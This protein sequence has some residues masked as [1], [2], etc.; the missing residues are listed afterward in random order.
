LVVDPA[1]LNLEA[2]LVMALLDSGA[3]A[4]AAHQYAHF[5]R[6]YE[7]DLGATPPS[8]ADL[9]LR[10]PGLWPTLRRTSAPK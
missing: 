6:A 4:A 2:S 3:T 10:K 1:A 8:L 9:S 7:E 5:A